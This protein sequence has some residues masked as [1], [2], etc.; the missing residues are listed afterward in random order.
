MLVCLFLGGCVMGPSAE[1]A[2]YELNRDVINLKNEY[3]KECDK[4]FKDMHIV[5]QASFTDENNILPPKVLE[6]LKTKWNP[7]VYLSMNPY[8]NSHINAG[9]CEFPNVSDTLIQYSA[10]N[11]GLQNQVTEKLKRY[12]ALLPQMAEKPRYAINATAI[13][14]RADKLE[15]LIGCTS[16]ELNEWIVYQPDLN[17]TKNI[18]C[19]VKYITA[20]GIYPK[21]FTMSDKNLEV[22]SKTINHKTFNVTFINKSDSFLSVN[23]VSF[24]VGDDIEAQSVN[25]ELPPY[26]KKN[27]IFETRSLFRDKIYLGGNKKYEPTTYGNAV[28]YKIVNTNVEQTLFKTTNFSYMKLFQDY[29]NELVK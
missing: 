12:K 7:N 24:Y 6:Y 14:I 28:K 29:L 2:H 17:I 25:L 10:D 16:D 4:K 8:S 20:E 26:A 18:Q 1:T 22:T 15:L 27:I 19:N 5:V 11:P 13:E 21:E 3:Y 9:Y 23:T